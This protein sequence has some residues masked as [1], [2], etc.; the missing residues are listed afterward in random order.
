MADSTISNITRTRAVIIQAWQ[1]RDQDL[2]KAPQM[3]MNDWETY[4]AP[5]S[6][7]MSLA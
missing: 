5:I 4:V 2:L 6:T 7:S 1:A 3:E